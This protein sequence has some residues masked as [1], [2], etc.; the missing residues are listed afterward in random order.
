MGLAQGRVDKLSLR[1]PAD[2][3]RQRKSDRGRGSPVG[4]KGDGDFLK[5][6]YWGN[7]RGV[8]VE[9]TRGKRGSCSFYGNLLNF[10][11]IL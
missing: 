2:R 11:K 8:S 7:R 10:R 5:F 9:K 3:R 6:F 4:Q 1:T